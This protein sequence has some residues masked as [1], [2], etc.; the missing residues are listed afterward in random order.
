MNI[1]F[2]T[3]CHCEISVGSEGDPASWACHYSVYSRR[4]SLTDAETV[5]R[6]LA[7]SY[8]AD[9]DI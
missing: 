4:E 1:N 6:H 8:I 3:V 2:C 9:A 7:H 5:P